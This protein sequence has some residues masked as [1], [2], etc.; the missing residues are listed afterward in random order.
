MKYDVFEEELKKNSEKP[1][2]VVVN[3]GTTVKGAIDNLDK[4]LEILYR[5]GFKDKFYIH[6]DGAL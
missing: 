3:V 1:A 2:I 4:I 6:C 5:N